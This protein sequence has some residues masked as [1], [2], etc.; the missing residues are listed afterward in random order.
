MSHD[1]ADLIERYLEYALA[2]HRQRA[3]SVAVDLLEEGVP[4]SRILREVLAP[5]QRE[6]GRRWERGELTV[7]E[8]HIIS[9]ATHS[10]VEALATT[11]ALS[12]THGLVVAVCAEHEWHALPALMVV[13]ELRDHG[14]G[15]LY[16]GPSVPPDD[17]SA[18]FA[19]HDPDAVAISCS[20]ALHL[21]GVT[22][23][24]DAAH[25][26]GLPVL[27]GGRALTSQRA[28]V[29]GADGWA[30]DVRDA[31]DLL[32]RWRQQPPSVSRD[33]ARLDPGSVALDDH[34][35]HR[36]DLAFSTLED[37][38]PQ[39]AR[40]TERQRAHTR[41]DLEYIARH[42]AAAGLVG[43]PELFTEFIDWLTDLLAHRGV[44]VSAVHEGLQA[45][46]THLADH[47]EAAR[48]AT[49]T[50]QTVSER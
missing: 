10:A 45:L 14:Q 26:H 36:A 32:A 6:A 7:A 2:G 1:P 28:A 25:A 35:G 31:A 30:A 49:T 34:A 24:A 29:L 47:P 37:R 4:K 13:E 19:R 48:L 43:E 9:G 27:A 46:A 50:L 39:L 21:R 23:V 16:L 3:V 8:E 40:Y 11:D 5:A 42:L 33:G 12:T 18:L 15:V 20:V 41:A 44:P 38:L 22:A 17:L